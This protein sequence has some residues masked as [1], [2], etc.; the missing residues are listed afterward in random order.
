MNNNKKRRK[1]K[2]EGI[3]KE[4]GAI[5]GVS[6]DGG[7]AAQPG[8]ESRITPRRLALKQWF[9]AP[10]AH[11]SYLEGKVMQLCGSKDTH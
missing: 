5:L 2:R 6:L 3:L 7:N 9:S 8:S 4:H 10:S 11:R 1:E